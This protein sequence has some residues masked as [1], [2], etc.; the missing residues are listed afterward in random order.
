MSD[1]LD[2]SETNVSRASE[3]DS[4][5]DVGDEIERLGRTFEVVRVIDE[6]D[7]EVRP[8]QEV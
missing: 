5:R 2:V 6:N 7:Y 8:T 1:T 3:D 4:P